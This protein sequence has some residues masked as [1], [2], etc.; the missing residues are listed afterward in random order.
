MDR[1]IRVYAKLCQ[2]MMKRAPCLMLASQHIARVGMAGGTCAV[3]FSD[4]I[5]R[6]LYSFLRGLAKEELFTVFSSVPP[7]AQHVTDH[8]RQK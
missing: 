3:T 8:C 7:H 6:S 1:R 5:Y 2:S 4:G